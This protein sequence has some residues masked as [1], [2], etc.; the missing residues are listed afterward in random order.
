MRG[1]EDLVPM[2]VDQI[3]RILEETGIEHLN[4]HVEC[5]FQIIHFSCVN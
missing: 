5:T 4:S 3:R 2:T 1:G